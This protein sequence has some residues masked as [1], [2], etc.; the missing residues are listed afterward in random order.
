MVYSNSTFLGSSDVGA[1]PQYTGDAGNCSLFSESDQS[2]SL[3]TK[4]CLPVFG[5]FVGTLWCIQGIRQYWGGTD[6][7][8]FSKQRKRGAEGCAYLAAGITLIAGSIFLVR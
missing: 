6:N 3:V 4:V 1:L 2:S 5:G 8:K 7:E